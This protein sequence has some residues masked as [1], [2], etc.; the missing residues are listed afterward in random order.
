MRVLLLNGPNLN[1][2]GTRD[3]EVY[4]TTTLEELET[5][6]RGW[7]AELG[8]AHV[9][10]YQSNHEG[11]LI[12]RLHGARG[13]VDGIVFNPGALTHTSYALHDA[14]QAIGI[15]TVETHISNV[16][17]REV[18][19]QHS[20]V[21]PACVHT[22]YG[23]GIDGYRWALRHLLAR[24]A[25]PILRVSYGE[26]DEQFAQ[27]RLPDGEGPFPLVVTVHGGFWRHHWTRDTIELSALDLVDRGVANL[28]V[29]YRRVGR[30]GGA[31]G[32][33]GTVDDVV[34][35]V[36]AALKHPLIS[37]DRWAIAGHSAGGQLALAALPRLAADQTPS[38]RLAVTMGGVADLVQAIATNMGGGAAAAY[39][40]AEDPAQVSPTALLPLDVPLLVVHGRQDDEVPLTQAQ[41]LIRAAIAA[42][43]Q[44]EQ[45][46]HDGG[47]YE[48]LEPS[49]PVWV[50]VAEHLVAA[51]R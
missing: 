13:S 6:F 14:I 47:H 29:E 28:N 42:G 20:A 43:D 44:V 1:L 33:T 8:I 37:P 46:I 27:L 15:P 19:R 25:R 50:A 16:E 30:A 2:L 38:P 48:Y 3:P 40:G 35:A 17:E 22:I 24:S 36:R 18:W 41:T 5:L 12:D 32:G 51:L 31:G 26:W 7:A 9:E 49:D 34:A 23:R 11:H 4:G 21:R 10:T 45:V 39:I